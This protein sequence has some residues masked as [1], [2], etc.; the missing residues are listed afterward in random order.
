[1]GCRA[2]DIKID[3]LEKELKELKIKNSALKAENDTLTQT[4][5]SYEIEKAEN[6]ARFSDP[7]GGW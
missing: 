1:M 2:R 3:Q 6:I 5:R 7:R 4:V